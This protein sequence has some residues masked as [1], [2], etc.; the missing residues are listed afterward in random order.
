M[1]DPLKYLCY[2][3][4]ESV[5]SAQTKKFHV[6]R[7]FKERLENSYSEKEDYLK[8]SSGNGSYL[9]NSDSFNNSNLFQN[10][11]ND[12]IKPIDKFDDNKIESINNPIKNPISNPISERDN[13]NYDNDK[14]EIERI[15]KRNNYY[16]MLKNNKNF[17]N[18]SVNSFD[19]NIM[20]YS[21]MSNKIGIM[22]ESFNEANINNVNSNRVIDKFNDKDNNNNDNNNNDNNNNYN[23]NDNDNDNSEINKIKLNYLESTKIKDDFSIQLEERNLINRE[24]P[25]RFYNT[26]TRS[27]S[28][29][30]INSSKSP[31]KY[32]YD[33]NSSNLNANFKAS[34]NINAYNNTNFNSSCFNNNTSNNI[35]QNKNLNISDNYISNIKVNN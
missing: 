16:N 35:N 31:K 4:S 14:E 28:K 12:L 11:K 27:I 17:N 34:L 22:K 13:C 23:D 19:K 33:L 2:P 3:C 29:E 24:N 7:K 9:K 25:R 26:R 18:D 20:Q 15:R 6:R 5:H 1:C 10:T 32:D 21:S 8:S 30:R